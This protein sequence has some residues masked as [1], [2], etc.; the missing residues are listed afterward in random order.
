MTAAASV[1]QE[2]H[3]LIETLDY[4]QAIRVLAM[5]G[6]MNDDGEFTEEEDQLLE[7]IAAIE[8]GEFVSQADIEREFGFRG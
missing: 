2:L 3:D 4:K 1:K 5:I 6:L 8:A 7:G